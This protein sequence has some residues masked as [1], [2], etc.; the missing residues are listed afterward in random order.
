MQ[1]LLYRILSREI[2]LTIN[3]LEYTIKAPDV[4]LKYRAELYK[5][6]LMDQ[7]RFDL[8]KLEWF[9]HYLIQN[10]FIDPDFETK[11]KN[12]N[13]AIKK[14]KVEL[15]LA[16]P[17]IESQ[18]QI[19]E[20]LKIMREK[21]KTY[22]SNVEFYQK[23]SL[24]HFTESLKNKFVLINSTWLNDKLVLD[25]KDI[26]L[27]LLTR[28]IDELNKIDISTT[29]FRNLAISD[30]WR[31]YY[32]ANKYDLFGISAIDFSEEQKILCG[33]TRM[34]QNAYEHPQCPSDEVI[35]DH[36]RFD[37]WIIT[38]QDKNKEAN[39]QPV[40]N[41]DSKYQEVF[42][43]AQSQEEANN[44]YKAN[45]VDGKRI[46]KERAR[47]LKGQGDVKDIQFRDVQLDVLKQSSETM[48]QHVKNIGK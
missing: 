25:E 14:F 45:S 17:R 41:L 20:N 7:Y 22:Y 4:K 38:E 16:G 43:T 11:I 27:S 46:L 5:K 28:L 15:Y 18:K 44:I 1:D 31:S 10:K 8:P 21:L 19:R 3:D 34:Y 37:G 6:E 13:S 35:K 9:N 29:E 26:D 2:V 40:T 48:S 42:V 32:L 39:K 30:D 23:N 47:V 24:E 36:D 33:Y 12:M